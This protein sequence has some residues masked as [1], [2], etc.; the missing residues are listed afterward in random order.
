MAQQF[1]RG[2]DLGRW[3]T[4]VVVFLG[5]GLGLLVFVGTRLAVRGTGPSKIPPKPESGGPENAGLENAR[6][7]YAAPAP[8]P[9]LFGS[10]SEKRSAAR[11]KGV[12]VAILISD[13]K[14]LT[15]PWTGFVVDRSMQGICL[16]VKRPAVP[17][18]VLTLRPANAPGG[19][20][21]IEVKV[22]NCRERKDGWM[23][24]CQFV[25]VPPTG[26]LL[27]FG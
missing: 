20:P 18:T 2:F 25:R 21:W 5:L 4:W 7:E 27:M 24:G 12:A 10:T 6:P 9:F 16:D 1:L 13:E 11:R 22:R 15:E 19:I 14:A 17:G 26:L 3:Q 8:D 23:I